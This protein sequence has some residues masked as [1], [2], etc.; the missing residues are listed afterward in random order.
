MNN[1]FKILGVLFIVLLYSCTKVDD[2]TIK[3]ADGNDYN[4]IK[5]GSQV[6]MKENLKTTKYNDGEPIPLI[7]LGTAWKNL[8]TEG[9]CWYQN[10]IADSRE[11]YG[12]LYNWHTVN[13]KKLCPK[14]WHVPTDDEWHTM[15]QSLDDSAS[16]TVFESLTAGNKLKEAG[17]TNWNLQSAGATNETGFTAL[18]GGYRNVI[19]EFYG[20]GNFGTWWSSTEVPSNDGNAYTRVMDVTGM[21][22][23]SQGCKNE[24]YSVRCLRN[25]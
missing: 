24:A 12:L 21:V 22:G 16:L 25:N 8:F 18:P 17:N 5:I 2:N 14:G 7:L 4:T 15:V 20:L 9:C 10:D 23:K 11:N 19:G 3:D 13:T 6:W 1:L